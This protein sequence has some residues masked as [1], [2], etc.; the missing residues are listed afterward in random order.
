MPNLRS[1]QFP[2]VLT[3]TFTLFAVAGLACAEM[4]VVVDSVRKHSPSELAGLQEGDVLLRWTGGTADA[5]INSPF[6]L[7]AAEVEAPKYPHI[8]IY[9]LHHDEAR[10]W[11]L[12][13][14]DW[15]VT[16]RAALSGELLTLY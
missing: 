14:S 3:A 9:G 2:A 16:T 12:P 1:C 13:P 8:T 11:R 6:D 5:E 10:E 4:G 7:V 15:G